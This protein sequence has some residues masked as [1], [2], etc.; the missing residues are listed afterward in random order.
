MQLH[1]GRGRQEL[2]NQHIMNIHSQTH[3]P[4]GLI[5]GERLPHLDGFRAIS[6][7][8]VLGA[9]CIQLDNFP[10]SMRGIWFF[11]FDGNLG[12]R[13]FFAISGFIITWLLMREASPNGFVSLKGFW[14]RRA[15][16]ILP[17]Y[18]LFLLAMV[19][20]QWLTP[21]RLT[22]H[23]WLGVLTFTANY[24]TLNQWL[25]VHLWSL[26]V[27]EQFYLLWPM[28]FIL[29]K[30]WNCPR[31]ALAVLTSVIILCILCQWLGSGHHSLPILGGFSFLRT[32]DSIAFGCIG[33]I[34]L[35]HYRSHMNL[36]IAR[37]RMWLVLTAVVT[38]ALPKVL[39]ALRL[40]PPWH[41]SGSTA[42]QGFGLVLLLIWSQL[43]PR[44]VVFRFLLF[45][46]IILIGT[47][48]Y[49][50]YLW[51]QIFCSKAAT[52]GLAG[53]PWWLNFPGWLLPSLILGMS[54][55]Y[56]IEQPIR[57]RFRNRRAIAAKSF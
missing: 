37:Y 3:P 54:S 56:L 32:S 53:T 21:W 20:L 4:V 18:C 27:E 7:G 45:K 43:E 33:A 50:I 40:C 44:K 55:Y 25:P 13:F 15:V 41:F 24:N 38:I 35:W 36:F 2:L 49:S 14:G 16:R 34:A 11:I 51:Q 19:L 1:A 23:G 9:H 52:F 17:A 22:Q 28:A 47:W 39:E 30:P 10:I 8:M 6:I 48:S 29:L 12:V 26:S 46:P 42:I 31:R 5:H 57:S